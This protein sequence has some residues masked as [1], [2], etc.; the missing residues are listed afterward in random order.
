[1]QFVCSTL[2]TVLLLMLALCPVAWAA[3]LD[4]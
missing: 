1:L 2:A 3:R 4:R